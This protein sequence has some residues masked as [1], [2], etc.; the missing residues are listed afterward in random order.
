MPHKSKLFP[1]AFG[2]LGA[3]GAAATLT[4]SP[5]GVLCAT[6]A[7]A[8]AGAG[9]LLAH[10]AARQR[11]SEYEALDACLS[12]NGRFGAELAPVWVGQIETSRSHMETAIAGL[13]ARFGA[14]VQRIEQSARVSDSGG[15]GSLA[16]VFGRSERELTQVVGGLE[17]A[18]AS[19]ASLVEQVHGLVGYIDELRQ[20]AADVA[21]IAQQTNLLAVNAA[22]EAARAGEAGRGFAVLAQEVRKLS[23]Q[24]GE[25]GRRITAKVQV[26]G[27]AIVAT[28]E[29]ADSSVAG[30]QASLQHSRDTIGSVLGEFRSLTQAMAQ[31]ADQLKNE[32]LGIQGEISEAL[33]QLQFQDRVA[34]I[35]SHVKDNIARLPEA[36]AEPQAQ[37]AAHGRLQPASAAQLLTELQATYAMA[38]EHVVHQRQRTG[39]VAAAAPVKQAAT[40][41]TFF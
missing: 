22:I 8:L 33:V 38:E 7:A 4:L 27:E 32:N 17:A 29:A 20:M 30:D 19:K 23:G 5:F 26:I 3:A 35:L 21:L 40:E 28:R 25:T 18:A 11:R 13:A 10:Q 41:V 16:T 31:A 34:Q 12:G 37:Y 9:L 14:I 39:G 36:L 24:S 2:L 1:W 6:V 15:D